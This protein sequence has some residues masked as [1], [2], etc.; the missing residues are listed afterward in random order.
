VKGRDVGCKSGLTMVPT[1]S[2]DHQDSDGAQHSRA[3]VAAVEAVDAVGGDGVV[4]G[5]AASDEDVV[6]AGS[7]VAEPAAHVVVR[8]NAADFGMTVAD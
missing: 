1:V 6:V 4:D 2:Q 7:E 8:L 3:G 5:A